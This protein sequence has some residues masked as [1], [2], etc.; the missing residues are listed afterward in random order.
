MKQDKL[1]APLSNTD[2]PQIKIAPPGPKSQEIL[3]FQNASESSAVSY[4]KG[5]PMALARGK[6]ATLED[7]DGNI[8]ID[9]FGGAGV[10]AL[11]HGHPDI[12]KE[13]HAEIDNVTH[14]LDIPTPTRQKMVKSP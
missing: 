13:A 8:Y 10:M 6:G 3:D 9:M 5:M 1:F 7:V 2:A 12:L 14:T 4:A 11:G